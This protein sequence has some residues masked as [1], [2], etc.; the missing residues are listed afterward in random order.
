MH[1]QLTVEI[2]D[3]GLGGA[4]AVRLGVSGLADRV[5]ALGGQLHVSSPPASGTTVRAVL[6]CG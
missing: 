5:L 3:D 4:A 6:P 1:G 2:T